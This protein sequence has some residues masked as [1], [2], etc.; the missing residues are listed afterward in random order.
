MTGLKNRV[1]E[2]SDRVKTVEKKPTVSAEKHR[3]VIITNIPPLLN[4]DTLGVAKGV[5]EGLAAKLSDGDV[6]PATRLE[7]N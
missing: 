1:A 6:T 3:E 7:S 4:E 5:F 2:L